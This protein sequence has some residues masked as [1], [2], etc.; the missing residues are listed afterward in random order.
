MFYCSAQIGFPLHD[1]HDL[2][3]H[4]LIET[5][6]RAFRWLL[7]I[8]SGIGISHHFIWIGVTGAG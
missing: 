7:P 5:S 3:M 8:H 6:W 4:I 2:T 1:C